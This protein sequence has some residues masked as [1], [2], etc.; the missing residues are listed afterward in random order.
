MATAAHHTPFVGDNIG[1]L[2]PF[3]GTDFKPGK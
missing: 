2:E 1:A 3:Y